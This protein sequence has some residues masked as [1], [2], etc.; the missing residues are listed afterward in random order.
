MGGVSSEG[1]KASTLLNLHPFPLWWCS[2][3]ESFFH[4]LSPGVCENPQTPRRFV[5]RRLF[6]T[7]QSF[8]VRRGLGCFTLFS[9]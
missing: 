4:I 1:A 8:Q 9:F 6:Q 7:A 2:F 3:G 5:N